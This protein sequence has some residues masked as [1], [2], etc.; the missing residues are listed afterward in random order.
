MA[1]FNKEKIKN[2]SAGS[3]TRI[4]SAAIGSMAS[5]AMEQ[6]LSPG[7]PG[8]INIGCNQFFQV[9]GGNAEIT[10]SG[11]IGSKN[12]F[13]KNWEYIDEHIDLSLASKQLR[14]IRLKLKAESDTSPE[15]ELAICFIAAAEDSAMKNDGPSVLRHLQKLKSLATPL[16]N[17]ITSFAAS[18][19]GNIAAQLIKTALDIPST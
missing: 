13:Q 17:F 1:F 14:E 11:L 4:V 18:T 16:T 10:G 6:V 15:K 8:S 9:A 2:S 7:S 3:Y 12:V 19:G 5:K